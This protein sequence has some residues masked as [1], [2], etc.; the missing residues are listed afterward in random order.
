MLYVR[1]SPKLHWNAADGECDVGYKGD[2]G[3]SVSRASDSRSKDRRFEP[4]LRQEYKKNLREF[5]RVKNVALTRYRC[6]QLPV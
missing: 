2:G 3:G 4:R 1:V 5:F 6:A